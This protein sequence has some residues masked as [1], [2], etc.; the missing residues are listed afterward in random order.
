VNWIPRLILTEGDLKNCGGAERLDRLFGVGELWTSS[1]KFRSAGYRDTVAD[2]DQRTVQPANPRHRILE[3][4]RTYGQWQV[5]HPDPATATPRADD[6]ALVLLGNCSGTRILLLSDLSR[7]GQ[8]ALLSRTND[9]RADIVIAGLPEKGEPLCDTLLAA[10][11]PRVI[12][13]AD[14]EKPV[15][16]RASPALKQRLEQSRFPV[17][18]TRTAGAVT[19]V[20]RTDGWT[21][22]TMDGQRFTYALP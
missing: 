22:R 20:T 19:I 5:L 2:F 14:S 10:I 21:L 9:L 1:V 11:H 16:R 8:S 7:D 18:Y 12:V 17:I 15:N 4:G 13:I 6:N 3:F